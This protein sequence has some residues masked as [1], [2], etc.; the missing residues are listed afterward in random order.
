LTGVRSGK[1]NPSS[2][3]LQAMNDLIYLVVFLGFFALTAGFTI[4][5]D[6]I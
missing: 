6:R 2:T 5:L 4:G 1:T 3:L